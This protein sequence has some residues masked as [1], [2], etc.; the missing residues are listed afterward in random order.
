MVILVH[1]V[2]HVFVESIIQDAFTNP[3]ANAD[4]ETFVVDTGESFA[5][6][7]VDF[8]EMM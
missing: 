6:Y 3:V 7:F 1:E 5:G 8:I 2:G 4:D